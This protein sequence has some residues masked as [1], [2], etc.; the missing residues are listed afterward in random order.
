[1]EDRKPFK[2]KKVLIVYNFLQ[3]ILSIK[4]FYNAC[5]LAWF[6]DYNWRCEPYKPNDYS[7]K[8]I[9]IAETCWLY[10]MSKFPELLDTVFFIMRKRFDQVSS[11]HVIH[12]GIMPFSTWWGVKFVPGG[13]IIIL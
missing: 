13:E 7:E 8:G 2:L 12:H 5:R 3:V 4:I 1:M 11:L 6:N 10:L 9:K